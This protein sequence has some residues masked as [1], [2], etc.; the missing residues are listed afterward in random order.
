[1]LAE[2]FK[3]TVSHILIVEFLLASRFLY[4]AELI[5]Y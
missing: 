4:T 2:R 1:M 3:I 5:N